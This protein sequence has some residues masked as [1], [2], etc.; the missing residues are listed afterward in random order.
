MESWSFPALFSV[1]AF[2]ESELPLLSEPNGCKN[3]L[4]GGEKPI[5]RKLWRET[6]LEKMKPAGFWGCSALTMIN[7]PSRDR[8]LMPNHPRK[9]E[10]IHR[11]ISWLQVFP[12][13]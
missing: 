9:G 3:N 6:I 11:K 2:Q 5:Y 12:W 10:G 1:S 13:M 4:K 8:V 7:Q